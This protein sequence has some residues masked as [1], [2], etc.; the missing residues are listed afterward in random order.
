MDT[1]KPKCLKCGRLFKSASGLKSHQKR[2]TSCEQ[3]I[4]EVTFPHPEKENLILMAHNIITK[5]I[6]ETIEN[7][8]D[9]KTLDEVAESLFTILTDFLTLRH[10][11]NTYEQL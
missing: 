4:P 2:K 1:T 7:S 11:S 9:N 6:T 3:Q 5:E 10:K 8:T